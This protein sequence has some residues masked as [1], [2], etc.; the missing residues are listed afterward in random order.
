MSLPIKTSKFLKINFWQQI[1]A[2]R[3]ELKTRNLHLEIK[4]STYI[5]KYN[6]LAC[7]SLMNINNRSIP[8]RFSVVI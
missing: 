4:Y 1:F 2:I 7:C 3:I 5:L 8:N 6:S